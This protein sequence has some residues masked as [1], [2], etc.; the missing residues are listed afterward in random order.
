MP[1]CLNVAHENFTEL[2]LARAVA[3]RAVPVPIIVTRNAPANPPLQ[4]SSLCATMT[5]CD[6]ATTSPFLSICTGTLPILYW[7][8]FSNRFQVSTLAV[9]GQPV[10]AP[11]RLGS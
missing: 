5:V 10:K 7:N 3:A 8:R 11:K 2:K 1:P 6:V 9:L 4:W